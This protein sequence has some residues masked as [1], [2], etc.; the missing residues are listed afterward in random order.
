MDAIIFPADSKEHRV[1]RSYVLLASLA[2]LGGRS[3]MN[4]NEKVGLAANI[5]RGVNLVSVA[6]ECA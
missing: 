1:L 2:K 5:G 6:F 3:G 4:T